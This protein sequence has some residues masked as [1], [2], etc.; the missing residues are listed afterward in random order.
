M[1]KS[2]SYLQIHAFSCL[3]FYYEALVSLGLTSF[4]SWLP[5]NLD[6]TQSTP[7]RFGVRTFPLFAP[8]ESSEMIS[9]RMGVVSSG[10]GLYLSVGK[11]VL[12]NWGVVY[13]YPLLTFLCH[14]SSPE[15]MKQRNLK[16]WFS[17]IF[18]QFREPLLSLNMR[19]ATNGI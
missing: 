9:S 18:L 8:T 6:R 15:I 10:L 11:S 1:T 2:W 3:L 4:W 16:V 14:V 13:L 19:S 7:K 12:L 17:T 5:L